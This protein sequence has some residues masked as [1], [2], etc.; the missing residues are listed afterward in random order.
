MI[1][2]RS[3]DV[4]QR[5]WMGIEA[6][7]ESLENPTDSQLSGAKSGALDSGTRPIDAELATVIDAWADLPEP[8]RAGIVAM[9]LSVGTPGAK[10]PS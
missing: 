5:E 9:V 6:P 1:T 10:R 7:P 2:S 4:A 3:K 8:I